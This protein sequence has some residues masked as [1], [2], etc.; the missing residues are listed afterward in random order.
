MVAGTAT[1]PYQFIE[2]RYRLTRRCLEAL[3]ESY[4]PVTLVTKG[5]LVVR[6][7]GVLLDLSKGAGC[8]VGFSISTVDRELWRRLESGTL[9]PEKR[10][11]AMERLS[12]RGVTAGVLIAPVVPGITDAPSNL[13]K[14]A[15][16]ASEHGARFLGTNVLYLKEGTKEHFLGF[17]Q[18]AY[19]DLVAV[20]QRLYPW[21]YAPKGLQG[22]LKLRVQRLKDIYGLKGLGNREQ[23]STAPRVRRGQIPLA[24]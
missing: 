19:P 5:T 2:G 11:E 21:S 13:G 23:S 14:V 7:M 24:I 3:A 20:Y 22:R 17:L 9:P 10:L 16:A 18:K 1:N 15:R 8:V 12:A 6:D 4:T